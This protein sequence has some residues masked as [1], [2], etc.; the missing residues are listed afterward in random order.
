MSFSKKSF[1]RK[2]YYCKYKDELGCT[3]RLSVDEQSGM[4]VRWV[5][6]HCHDNDMG[7]QIANKIVAEEVRVAAQ[8]PLTNPRTAYQKVNNTMLS[9]KKLSSALPYL[10]TETIIAKKIQYERRKSCQP[11]SCSFRLLC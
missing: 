5:R 11:S 3:A 1:G 2:F 8:N 9:D 10:P 6:D 4:I 7:K